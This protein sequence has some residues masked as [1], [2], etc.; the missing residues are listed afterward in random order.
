MWLCTELGRTGFR[1]VTPGSNHQLPS[2]TTGLWANAVL[3]QKSQL[4]SVEHPYPEASNLVA[5]LLSKIAG[6]KVERGSLV[7][8]YASRTFLG[9]RSLERFAR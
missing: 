4:F 8:S 1:S 5:I 3:L 9:E 6:A 7:E 2:H